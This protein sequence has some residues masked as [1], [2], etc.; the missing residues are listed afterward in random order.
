MAHYSRVPRPPA[1]FAP[2]LRQQ[3]ARHRKG[4][5]ASHY[6]GLAATGRVMAPVALA[7]IVISVIQDTSSCP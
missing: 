2:A 6:A 3:A 5:V 4:L 7:P 1:L